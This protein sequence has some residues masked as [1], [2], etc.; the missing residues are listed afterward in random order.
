MSKAASLLGWSATLLSAWCVGCGNEP[1]FSLTYARPARQEID[2]NIRRLAVASRFQVAD[3]VDPH[4]GRLAAENLLAELRNANGTSRRFDQIAKAPASVHQSVPP[5][6]AESCDGVIVG[7]VNV[8]TTSE[9]RTRTVKDLTGQARSEPYTHRYVGVQTVFTLLNLRQGRTET[10]VALG[11]EYDSDH[12]D[13]ETT[14]PRLTGPDGRPETS[15]RDEAER[16]LRRSA[17]QFAAWITPRVVRQD[18]TLATGP[19]EALRRGNGLAR[20]G[21][22]TEAA[23]C[24]RQALDERPGDHGAMYNLGLMHEAR[25][26]F[27]EALSWYD[28]ALADHVD[29]Q[30]VKARRR[31][32]SLVPE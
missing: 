22:Y 20:A 4:W 28:R 31:V 30:Y 5:E 10:A 27:A 6:L 16:L 8:V 7:A 19:S 23:E 12:D 32:R 2:P 21:E 25:R 11:G 29:D 13:A 3:A 17:E 9:R 24:Y 26:Q 1:T 14:R 18:V 15:S